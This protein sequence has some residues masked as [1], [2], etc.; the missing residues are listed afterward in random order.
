MKIS[1][2]DSIKKEILEKINAKGMV[3]KRI[4]GEFSS[5]EEKLEM[6]KKYEWDSYEYF[7][8]MLPEMEMYTNFSRSFFEKIIDVNLFLLKIFI[9]IYIGLLSIKKD[10]VFVDFL[11]VSSA[12]QAIHILFIISTVIISF[13]FVGYFR[14]TKLLRR[15][16]SISHKF[17]VMMMDIAKME[18]KISEEKLKFENMLNNF[19][20]KELDKE[21]PKILKDK[22]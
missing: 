1:E 2:Y 5:L 4:S 12:I 15:T 21:L 6:Q 14:L 10:T 3:E 7:K 20:N 9:P 22:V 11:N 17:Q 13:S 8:K 18:S 16:L 19:I